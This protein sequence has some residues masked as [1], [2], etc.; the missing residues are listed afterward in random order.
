MI[1]PP[2]DRLRGTP[3]HAAM[4]RIDSKIWR[5]MMEYL[6]QRHAEI[7]RQ[8]F[9]EE[10][11]PIAL[12]GGLLQIHTRT[13]I[14]QN[15]LQKRCLEPFTDAAQH[16]TG[17]LIAVR[18]VNGRPPAASAAPPPSATT[19]AAET[20]SEA[21]GPTPTPPVSM[22]TPPP[23]R[24]IP[25]DAADLDAESA[26]LSPDNSFDNFI[27]GPNNQLAYAASVAVADQPGTAYNPL[28]IHGGVGLGKTHL[29]QAIC[30]TSSTPTQTRSCSTCPAT[31]S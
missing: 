16:A 31:R 19:P 18:F 10:L 28:F 6:R 9:F 23:P 27:I 25:A 8:W 24:V 17:Q 7:C 21:A 5:D 2:P 1:L 12:E 20:P 11:E 30:Q 14:Q 22:R 15:Y 29:L 4:P 26:V 3:P 13:P